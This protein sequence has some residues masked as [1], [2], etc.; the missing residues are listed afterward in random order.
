M[1]YDTQRSSTDDSNKATQG[2]E[3]LF[4]DW[5]VLLLRLVRYRVLRFAFSM[6]LL[7][8]IFF[9]AHLAPNWFV[10]TVKLIHIVGAYSSGFRLL[11]CS[12]KHFTD[13]V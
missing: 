3:L 11:Q 4:Q 10:S 1:K 13:L 9:Y 5:L 8:S 2:F 6:V 7:R 12:V